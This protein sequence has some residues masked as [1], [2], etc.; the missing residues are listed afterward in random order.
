MNAGNAITIGTILVVIVAI[1]VYAG[2][3]Y[4]SDETVVVTVEEK[5]TK[6]HSGDEK[7]LFSSENDVVYSVEDSLWLFR[8]DASDRYAAIEPGETY[9]ITTYGWRVPFLTWYKNAIE[10]EVS[11]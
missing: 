10:M 9:E 5:W 3:Y 4:A 7:Y 8:F 11:Y 6:Y 2:A 1:I